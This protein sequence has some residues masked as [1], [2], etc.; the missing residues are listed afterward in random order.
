MLPAITARSHRPLTS[1]AGTRAAMESVRVMPISFPNVLDNPQDLFASRPAACLERPTVRGKFL[2][3]GNQ[4]LYVR[5]VTYGAFA[6]NSSGD[7]F[8]ER[9]ETLRDFEL[10]QAGGIN[11]IL[12]YTVPPIWLL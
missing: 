9:P 1:S 7:Q 12:T 4:K 8:P 11:T 10:M 2:Y 6:P 5:G 3:D